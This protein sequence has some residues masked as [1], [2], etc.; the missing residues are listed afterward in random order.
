MQARTQN[1]T[2]T[3]RMTMVAA[4]LAT[5]MASGSAQAVQTEGMNP[6]VPMRT[7]MQYGQGAWMAPEAVVLDSPQAW[8]AWNQECV[9]GGM[10]MGA[11]PAPAGVDWA[12]EVVLVVSAGELPASARLTLS[13]ARRTRAGVSVNVSVEMGEGMGYSAPCHVVTLSRHAARSVQLNCVNM[14]VAGLPLTAQVYGASSLL[15]AGA[16][17]ST[18]PSTPTARSWGALKADY[19]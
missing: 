19:R 7:L 1:Q 16:D 2:R 8:A 3:A 5:M 11:E 14:T 13:D 9:A 15:V 18:P 10:A 17:A 6:A 4:V 12:H